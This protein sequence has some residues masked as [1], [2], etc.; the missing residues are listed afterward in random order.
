MARPRQPID[1]IAAKGRKHLTVEEYTE[2]KQSEV[3]ASADQVKPPLFL[4]KKERE[5]F[6]ELAGQLIE[7]KIMTNLDCDVLAR[8]IK[9]ETE[10]VKVTKQLVKIKFLP[11]KKSMV[12]EE[13]QLAE[14]YAR[15]NFLSKIQNRLMKACN[16]NARELGLTISSRCRLVIPKEKDEKPEN[17]FMKY[18]KHAQGY[19]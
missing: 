2:R 3:T 15:Y 4:S 6:M 14:Q 19:G 1:L 5:K 12:S 10:Y 11:D 7:L 9:A 16:E 17:K 18:T 8:Y 13:T